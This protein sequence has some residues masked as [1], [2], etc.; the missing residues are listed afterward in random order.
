MEGVRLQNSIDNIGTQRRLIALRIRASD[1]E[2]W[3]RSRQTRGRARP[4]RSEGGHDHEAE[5]TAS[6]VA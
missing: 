5:R 3:R 1:A 2:G 4:K 6:P